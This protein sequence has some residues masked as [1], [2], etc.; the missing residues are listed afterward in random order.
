M[1]EVSNE[2]LNL[3]PTVVEPPE[4]AD[5]EDAEANADQEDEAEEAATGASGPSIDSASAQDTGEGRFAGLCWRLE[6]LQ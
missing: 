2:R 5:S 6:A 4:Q 3:D 1:P